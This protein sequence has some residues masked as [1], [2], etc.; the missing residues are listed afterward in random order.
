[1]IRRMMILVLI[2]SLLALTAGDLLAS[3]SKAI[4]LALKV[5]GDVKIRKAGADKA[6]ALKFGTALDDGDQINTGKD[7]Q[8]TIIFADD[9]SQIS[10]QPNTEVVVSGKRD[11]QSNIAKRITMDIGEVFVR[12]DKQRGT[13]EVATP[14]SVAS[15]KGTQWWV[16]VL[17]DGTTTVY[18]IEGFVNLLNRVSGT[19]LEV[20]QG[21]Q[22]VSDP[23][24]GNN[25]GQG[26]PEDYPETPADEGGQ[27][28][29]ME[30]YLQDPDGRART[31]ILQYLQGAE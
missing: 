28:R 11:A 3:D 15:V 14:T 1:M 27:P 13:L 8:V 2:A 5:S 4:A 30:I 31:V 21:Q 26:N 9:K 7:G 24:G 12:V 20:G 19:V 17:A 23:Q 25:L 6:V 22:G 10:L 18:T 29:T 16:V